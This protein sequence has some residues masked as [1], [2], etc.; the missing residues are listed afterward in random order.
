MREDYNGPG[1]CFLPELNSV[2]FI[3]CSLMC[4]CV[5]L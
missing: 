2:F 3:L 5:I 1:F 4:M